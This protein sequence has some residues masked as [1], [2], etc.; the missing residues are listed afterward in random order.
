VQPAC[1]YNNQLKQKDYP[2]KKEEKRRK[3]EDEENV[4]R[5]KAITS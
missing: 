5:R 4:N 3:K 2:E 1:H